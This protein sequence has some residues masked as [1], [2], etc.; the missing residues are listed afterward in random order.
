[1]NN[2]LLKLLFDGMFFS[3]YKDIPPEI[4]RWKNFRPGEPN[5][6]CPCCGE[7]FLDMDSMDMLQAARELCEKPFKIN[8]GHRCI[9]HNARVGGAPLSQHKEMAFD[10]DLYGHDIGH[11]LSSL[12]KAGFSTFGYYSTFIHTDKRPGRTWAT[13]GGKE[14]WQQW[15]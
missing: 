7:F 13:K 11:L 14:R 3:H 9:I 2:S 4:W 10:I 1:M 12:K 15:I 6:F 5:L 8:S